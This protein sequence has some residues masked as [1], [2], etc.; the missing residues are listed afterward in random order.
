MSVR[1]FRSFQ[2]PVASLNLALQLCHLSLRLIFPACLLF[3]AIECDIKV[4]AKSANT[5][6]IA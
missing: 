1:C 5:P 2:A 3:N 4:G 6:K